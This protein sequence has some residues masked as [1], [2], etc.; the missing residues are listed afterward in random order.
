M[1]AKIAWSS[2]YMARSFF[3]KYAFRFRKPSWH[4]PMSAFD[5]AW[6]VLS[7]CRMRKKYQT[8]RTK[9][10]E[11]QHLPAW[12]FV[13]C[14][15]SK[16]WRVALPRINAVYFMK[17]QMLG[18][19]Q[20]SKAVDWQTDS[21]HGHYQQRNRE[22]EETWVEWMV[23]GL[24]KVANLHCCVQGYRHEVGVENKKPADSLES[25][26]RTAISKCCQLCCRASPL[27]IVYCKHTWLVELVGILPI[28]YFFISQLQPFHPW[29]STNMLYAQCISMWVVH[30]HQNQF[31]DMQRHMAT[32]C[33]IAQKLGHSAVAK[34]L[35]PIHDQSSRSS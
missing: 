28:M 34:R 33:Y 18:T 22:K 24:K 11:Q 8:N 13:K 12:C 21:I 10:A 4:Q 2:S 25:T 14:V 29:I 6:E 3:T 26:S 20:A 19:L 32:L 16:I 15:E 30:I 35:E 9:P 23:P 1:N 7:L 17:N 5:Q 27:Y 31:Y